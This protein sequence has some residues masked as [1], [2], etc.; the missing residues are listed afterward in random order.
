M[1][2]YFNSE[3]NK[4]PKSAITLILSRLRQAEDMQKVIEKHIKFE[5][6]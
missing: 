2:S 3:G 1:K 6:V 5:N 4:K